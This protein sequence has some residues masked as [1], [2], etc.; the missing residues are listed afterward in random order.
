[1]IPESVPRFSAMK[2]LSHLVTG[3]VG[4]PNPGLAMSRNTLASISLFQLQTSGS[5]WLHEA[6]ELKLIDHQLL[7]LLTKSSVEM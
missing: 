7:G 4:Q 6:G 5:V 3:Y 1:M 2:G